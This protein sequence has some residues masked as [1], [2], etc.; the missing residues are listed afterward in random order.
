MTSINSPD[1]FSMRNLSYDAI[2]PSTTQSPSMDPDDPPRRAPVHSRSLV[3]VGMLCICIASFVIQSE[4]AQFV[5]QTSDFQKPYFILYIGH[6]S[7]MLMLPLQFIT[8]YM[9]RFKSLQ[10]TGIKNQCV[11]VFHLAYADFKVSLAELVRHVRSDDYQTA[12]LEDASEDQLIKTLRM[13]SQQASY[14][15][16]ISVALAIMITVPAY[17]W[18]ITVNLISM[19]NLTAVYNTACFWAYLFSILLLGERIVTQKV[20]AV[21]LCVFGVL[22]MALWSSEDTDNRHNP[23]GIPL[24][25]AGAVAYGYYEVFYK[26]YA[27]PVKATVLFANVVTGLI[28]VTSLFILWVPIPILHFSGYEIF[29]LPSWTTLGYIFAIALTGVMYNAGFMC[30]IALTNPVFAAV[31]IMLTIPAVAVADVFVT[32][33]MVPASTIAGSVCILIGFAALSYELSKDEDQEDIGGA[34]D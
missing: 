13:S 30:L 21:I 5:Q 22:I 16:K 8:E 34:T 15:V 18:Y 19:A 2:P 9:K 23:L 17:L 32:G 26:Q 33:V 14:L 29:Q 10:S 27:S 24:A 4:L 31:G 20:L 28:G 6:S 25:V 7:Y 3:A 11:E 1:D 12:S